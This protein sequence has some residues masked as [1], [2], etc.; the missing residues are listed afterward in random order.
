[1]MKTMK[2]VGVMREIL[3]GGFISSRGCEYCGGI[4]GK[5]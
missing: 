2:N 5:G 4:T 1:M 3:T